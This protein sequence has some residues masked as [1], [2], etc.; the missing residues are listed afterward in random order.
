MS[1]L[2]TGSIQSNQL[3][4]CTKLSVDY[5][6]NSVQYRLNACVTWKQTKH[7]KEGQQFD[8]ILVLKIDSDMSLHVH[9]VNDDSDSDA[10]PWWEYWLRKGGEEQYILFSGSSFVLKLVGRQHWGG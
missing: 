10:V 2:K 5:D 7:P 9:I 1:E 4:I 3:I 6:Y 8:L